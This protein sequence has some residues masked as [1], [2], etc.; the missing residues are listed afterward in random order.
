MSASQ[1]TGQY[2]LVGKPL[3][4]VLVPIKCL[5]CGSLDIIRHGQTSNEKQRFLCRNEGCGKTFIREY[6]DKGRLPAIKQRIVDMAVNG[7]GVR[8]TARIVN[9]S[10]DTVISELK[11]TARITSN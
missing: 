5:H 11:K 10:T 4:M 3:V 6:S 8:D 7:S 2:L 9:I 1:L